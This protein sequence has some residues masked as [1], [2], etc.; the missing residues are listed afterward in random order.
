MTI[1]SQVTLGL[2]CSSPQ[3]VAHSWPN[4]F[5]ITSFVT[6]KPKR[7]LLVSHWS[8]LDMYHYKEYFYFYCHYSF[9]SVLPNKFTNVSF[10]ISKFILSHRILFIVLV[11]VVSR[12]HSMIHVQVVQNG[13]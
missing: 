5:F 3:K 7:C 1:Y 6:L 2:D 13:S 8:F 9:I 12:F 11:M 4:L 10:I